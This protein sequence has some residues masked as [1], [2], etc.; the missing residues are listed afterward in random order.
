MQANSLQGGKVTDGRPKSFTPRERGR[1]RERP[2]RKNLYKTE[3]GKH[4]T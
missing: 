3:N 2:K 1:K 4:P